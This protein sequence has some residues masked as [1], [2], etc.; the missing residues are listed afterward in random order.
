VP[1]SADLTVVVRAKRGGKI[2]SLRDADGTEWLTQSTLRTQ[3]PPGTTFA[4]A[5]MAGWDECA[6]SVTACVVG[7][8]PIPDHGDAWDAAWEV[9]G[10]ALRHA[11][12]SLPYELERTI[13]PTPSGG[14]RLKYK[15]TTDVARVPFMWVSHPQF[16]AAPGTRVEFQDPP[17]RVV[18]VLADGW[19]SQDW[20]PALGYIDQISIGG[21][22]KL[23]VQ[24]EERL[25]SVDLVRPDGNR[26]RMTLSPA[27]PYLG[28]WF[29]HGAWAPTPVICIEPAIAYAD[30]LARAVELGTAPVL[31]P[32]TP[33]EWWLELHRP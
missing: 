12:T 19:P 3:P 33:L 31:T 1:V 25:A 13:A 15:A 9:R 28:L 29:D 16:E 22:R 7:R 26:L 32:A 24:P 17:R 5:E 27:I 20:S 6:P 30:S 2:A 4:E 23:Y 11:G 21:C 10:S 8:V 14:L 18:D